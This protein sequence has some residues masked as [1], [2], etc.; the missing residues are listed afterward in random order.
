MM[1]RRT[2]VFAL[3]A[4]AF[5]AFG[6]QGPGYP[7][8]Q[9]ALT[10]DA[11]VRALQN[12]GHVFFLRHTVR[13]VGEFERHDQLDFR[14]CATQS[15]L[16]EIGRN[17]ATSIGESMRALKIPLGDVLAS[18]YCRTMDAARLISQREPKIEDDIRGDNAKGFQGTSYKNLEKMVERPL[19][20]GTNRLISGHVSGFEAMGGSPYLLEGE[21]AVFRMI[22][23]KR[24]LIARLRA[25]DWK[26]LAAP[27]NRGP[28]KERSAAPDPKLALSGRPLMHVLGGGGYTIYF[29]HGAT[30]TSQ[31]DRPNI[32]TADCRTQRNLSAEGRATAARI[33]EAVATLRL[34]MGDIVASPYCRT[35]ETAKLITGKDPTPSDAVRGGAMPGAAPDFSGLEKLLATPVKMGQN[36]IIVGHVN[37]QEVAGQPP[38]EEAEAMVVRAVE[39]GGWVVIARLKP[40]D[41]TA[42]AKILKPD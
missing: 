30:D 33:G 21:I 27:A 32:D 42:L 16:T 23:G 9:H 26:A 20:P 36:R 12:G 15:N 14:N 28:G 25:E 5:Q 6:Q 11:L 40:D 24:T 10:G 31:R 22:D 13:N 29:R 35:M 39:G 34:R 37:V 38:L 17:Q 19:A 2:M 18:P 1:L 4:T 41:W 8:P 7:D 3:L